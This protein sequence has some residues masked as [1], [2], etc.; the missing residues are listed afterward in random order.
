MTSAV[1]PPGWPAELPPPGTEEFHAKVVGWL[2]DRAP[3]G[4][5]G[6]GA[7]RANP[8]ALARMVVYTCTG[9]VEALRAA[10]AAVR[11]EFGQLLGADQIDAILVDLEAQ[12]AASSETLRQAEQVSEALAGATWRQRL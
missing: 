5:R 3:A 4:F 9:E 2:L 7:L 10:Y 1:A 6:A 12:G 8:P 11:R